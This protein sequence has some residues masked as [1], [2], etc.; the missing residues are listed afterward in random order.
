MYASVADSMNNDPFTIFSNSITPDLQLI[1]TYST[2]L[3]NNSSQISTNEQYIIIATLVN[4]KLRNNGVLDKCPLLALN[5]SSLV[6]SGLSLLEALVKMMKESLYTYIHNLGKIIEKNMPKLVQSN[7]ET[8]RV[9]IDAC[10]VRN[11]PLQKWVN[12]V[13]SQ[14]NQVVDIYIDGVLTSSCVLKG[15]PLMST[16]NAVICPDG[17]F[18]GKISNVTFYGNALTANDVKNIYNMGPVIQTTIFTNIPTWV[19]YVI[20]IIILC[21][22]T[23]SMFL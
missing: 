7:A 2:Q 11:I 19:Y 4:S 10:I 15:Y 23:Y 8:N 3:Q 5:T 1:N 14:Y 22:I 12:V 17:G 21:G 6:V 18:D 16:E 20:A 9:N 13:V